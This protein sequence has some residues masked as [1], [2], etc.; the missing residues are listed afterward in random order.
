MPSRSPIVPFIAG[1]CGTAS[2]SERPERRLDPPVA[3][4]AAPSKV[5]AP[6]TPGENPRFRGGSLPVYVRMRAAW[7]RTRAICVAHA[8]KRAG[9]E[10]YPPD[11]SGCP[12]HCARSAG[13]RDKSRC[14]AHECARHHCSAAGCTSRS[15]VGVFFEGI[16]GLPCPNGASAKAPRRQ[17]SP[18]VHPGNARPSVRDAD[19]V[20]AKMAKAAA[21]Q[22]AASGW[23]D[24]WG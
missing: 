17:S 1:A 19:R 7:S 14:G 13:R 5:I 12:A 22:A 20:R 23:W 9:P 18:Q 8:L 16:G 15:R 10:G 3:A 24:A 2:V 11:S 21:G 4:R 6:S